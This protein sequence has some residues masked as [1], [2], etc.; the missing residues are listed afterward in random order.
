MVTPPRKRTQQPFAPTPLDFRNG[1]LSGLVGFV[2]APSFGRDL[3]TGFKF[4][5]VTGRRPR[6]AGASYGQATSGSAGGITTSRY[7]ATPTPTN[8]TPTTNKFTAVAVWDEAAFGNSLSIAS[9][10]FGVSAGWNIQERFSDGTVKFEMYDG[11]GVRGDF[12]VTGDILLNRLNVA[13]MTADGLGGFACWINGRKI[14]QTATP[15]GSNIVYE[16]N[17]SRLSLIDGGSGGDFTGAAGYGYYMALWTRALSPQEALSISANP[18]QV[19]A[20]E[21][22]SLVAPPSG[23]VLP[24]YGSLGDFDPELTSMAW[25]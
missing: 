6:A 11:G 25:F 24:V 23:A 9:L 15:N 4:Q 5:L 20:P 12:G 18:W 7:S 16:T 22:W 1:L 3:I 10:G 2:D 14:T 21:A 8:W 13:V 19:Y 17:F